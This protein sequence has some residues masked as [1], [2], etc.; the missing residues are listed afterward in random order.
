VARTP[1]DGK[2]P[3]DMGIF[4]ASGSTRFRAVLLIALTSVGAPSAPGSASIVAPPTNRPR[5]ES[6]DGEA[7]TRT[8]HGSVAPDHASFCTE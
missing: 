3:I 4:N 1:R 8:T 2:S 5:F 7:L 6:A